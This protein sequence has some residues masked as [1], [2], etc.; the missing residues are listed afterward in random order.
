MAVNSNSTA[1]ATSTCNLK[2]Y[3]WDG[4]NLSAVGYQLSLSGEVNYKFAALDY[5][6]F[7]AINSN[8]DTLQLASI[9]RL[10]T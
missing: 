5:Y 1:P 10:L 2:L 6:S 9:P 8:N 3:S 7:I 4:S